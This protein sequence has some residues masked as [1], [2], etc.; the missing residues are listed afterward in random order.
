VNK[1]NLILG[2]LFVCPIVIYLFFATGVYNFS[3]LPIVSANVKEV[4]AFKNLQGE[5]VYLKDK[6]TVLGFLGAD[7][8]DRKI[9]VYNLHEEIYKGIH[10]SDKDFQMLMLMPNGTE[11]QVEEVILELSRYA[12]IDKWQFAFGTPKAIKEVYNSLHTERYLD[13]N[14]GTDFTF[15][16]DKEQKVRA[17]NDVKLKNCFGYDATAVSILHKIMDNDVTV[18]L[19]EYNAALKSNYTIN[20]R[21]AVLK[22]NQI[23]EKK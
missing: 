18:L 12:E 14:L 8:T 4:S 17:S 21:D 2:L 16:I 23:D 20:R 5:Q 3:A 9:N 7:L 10:S 22:I 15:I 19:F 11:P 13:S 1:K 6:L